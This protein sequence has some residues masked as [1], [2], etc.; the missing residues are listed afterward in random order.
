ML[1]HKLPFEWQE[2]GG[3]DGYT[4]VNV[5]QNWLE[6]FEKKDDSGWLF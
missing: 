5:Q 3:S 6:G 1:K 2:S 4:W